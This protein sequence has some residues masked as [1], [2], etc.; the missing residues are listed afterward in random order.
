MGHGDEGGCIHMALQPLIWA[1]ER[2]RMSSVGT[3]I[4][5]ASQSLLGALV[6]V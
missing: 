3:P 6:G 1:S 4:G 2:V 5:K